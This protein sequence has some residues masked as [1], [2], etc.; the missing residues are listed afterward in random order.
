MRRA[1]VPEPRPAARPVADR[2]V[3][4]LT[5]E[6]R[7]GI[8]IVVFGFDAAEISQIRRIRALRALGHD[9][10][11]FTMR[12]SNM[13]V[14]FLPEWPNVHLFDTDNKRLLRRAFVVAGSIVKM[15]GH[16]NAVRSADLIV[17]RNLD[18]LAIAAAA[19]VMAGADDVP[20]IYEC[21]DIN[22]ALTGMSA[23]SKAM[24]RAERWLLDQI[25]LLAVSSPGFIRNYFA[26][27]QDYAGPWILWENKLAAGSALPPRPRT[28][29]RSP[30]PMRLGW[31]G[32]IRCAASLALLVKTSQRMAGELELHIHGV[33]HRHALPDLDAQIAGLPNVTFH[34]PYDYPY[35]LTAIYGRLDLVWSQD[36]WQQGGNSDWLLPNRV[37]EA[38]WC[39][40]PSIAVHGTETGRRVADDG[41]G[42]TI[43]RA[44]PDALVARLGALSHDAIARRAQALL[45]RPESD[46]VDDGAELQGAID[47]ALRRGPGDRRARTYVA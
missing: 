1:G 42:W 8:R 18:M 32:T 12:R 30:G 34:G 2:A 21:L 43:A 46:F 29:L 22:G 17:A 28:A 31:V 35:A 45:D 24:R 44:E 4:A 14:D 3:G 23:R 39:G 26:T 7:S 25:A 11:S 38:S 41:L 36:L 40:C 37:Y 10:V 6:G 15:S 13:N 5:R 20:L 47:F 9:V 19:R 33:V 27:T 16:R